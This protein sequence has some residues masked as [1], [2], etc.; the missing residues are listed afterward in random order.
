[1]D[2]L[3]ISSGVFRILTG[4]L[5]SSKSLHDTVQSFRNHERTIREL[6]SELESLI[7]VLESLRG[8]VTSDEGPVVSMLK[9]PVLRC[10]QICQDFKA[11]I[12]KC[13]RHS[14]GGS[15]TSFRDW[16][17]IRYMGG[18]V[19]DFKD[20]L[21]GYK[22]T[23]AVALGSLNMQ[24][25]QVTREAMD[26]HNEMIQETTAD[27]E[28]HLR[29]ID[30]KLAGIASLLRQE[31]DPDA[32]AAAAA[33]ESSSTA[34]MEEERRRS[35]QQ[36]LAICESAIAHLQSLQNDLPPQ[37]QQQQRDQAEEEF[38]ANKTALALSDARGRILV[39][40][41]ELQKQLAAATPVKPP[42]RNTE[43]I[44]LLPQQQ[45]QQQ[46]QQLEEDRTQLLKE[47]VTAR[48][49]LQVCNLAAAAQASRRGL[50]VFDDVSAQEDSQQ[51][52]VTTAGDLINA[53]NVRAGNSSTQWL[54]SMTDASLQQLCAARTASFSYSPSPANENG[55]SS[56]G[57]KYGLGYKLQERDTLGIKSM[58][59]GSSLQN[60]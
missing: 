42:P 30:Q 2:P 29:D 5:D 43:V 49:C 27:L 40:M 32:T 28:A 7:Q 54:G 31:Q 6:R 45:Q 4:A 25:A 53:K 50:H 24:T 33:D 52:I 20:M 36:C 17:R 34:Q 15:R 13:T 39:T 37:Q 48:Q 57:S 58:N 10:H 46:Q 35:V 9:N 55:S 56:G 51:V 59:V 11:V 60:R 1:M 8:V 16:T 23:I 47:L 22:A 26:Q 44:S 14:S 19:R 3:T 21:A 41:T 38:C 12:L 18:D